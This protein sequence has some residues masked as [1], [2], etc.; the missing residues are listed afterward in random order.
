M[1][2][3]FQNFEHIFL[4][5]LKNLGIRY[6]FDGVSVLKPLFCHFLQIIMLIFPDF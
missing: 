2:Y 3:F 4:I 5:F 1:G 6:Y